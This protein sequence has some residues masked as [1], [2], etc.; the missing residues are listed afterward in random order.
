M[1]VDYIKRK[2]KGKFLSTMNLESSDKI[3]GQNR[4]LLEGTGL[5]KNSKVILLNFRHHY[6]FK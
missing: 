1:S 5:V 2:P 4:S 3:I 6:W